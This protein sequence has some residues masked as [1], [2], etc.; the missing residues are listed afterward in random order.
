MNPGFYVSP[1]AETLVSITAT[2]Y[3]VTERAYKQFSPSARNCY[4]NNEFQPLHFNRTGGFRLIKQLISYD[5]D[6]SHRYDMTNCLYASLIEAVFKNCK[7]SPDV[8][9]SKDLQPCRGHQILCV[10]V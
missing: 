8:W 4:S 6:L 7:C 2:S 10:K 5:F 3:N 9:A 1:G